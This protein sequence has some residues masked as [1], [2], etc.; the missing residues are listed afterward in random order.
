[1]FFARFRVLVWIAVL[2][3]A[4]VVYSCDEPGKERELILLH[5][6]DSHGSIV[7]VDSMGGM[8]ER[9]TFI[10][11]IREK[12]KHVLFVDAGDFNTGQAASNMADAHPDIAAY[13]YMG[14]DAVTVG[15]H[16]FDKPLEVLLKQ[17][18]WADF[19][20]VVSNIRQKGK[21]LGQEYLIKEIGGIKVGVFGITTVHTR[22]ISVCADKLDFEEEIHTAARMV[23]VL[24]GQGAD[25]V[26]GLVHLGFTETTPDYVTSRKLASQVD[27]IDILVDGHSHSYIEKPEWVNRT[28]IVTANQSGRYVGMGKLRVK[29]H[30]LTG[31]DWKPVPIK[32]YA[33]D[34]MLWRQL[35]PYIEVAHSDLQTVVGLAT[36]E[37]ALYERDEN[38][39]RYRESSLGNLVADALKWKATE[40]L[41]LKADF[42]L[43]NS[44]GIRAGLPAGGITREEVLSVLPFAN[45]LEVIGMSGADVRRLFTFIASVTPGNGAFAQVSGDVHVVYDR[46]ARQVK[47]LSIGGKPVVDTMIYY[48]A[49]CDYVAAGKDGYEAGLGNITYRENTSRLLSDVLADYI[50]MKGR[51][52]P[53]T[54]GRIEVK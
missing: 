32:G 18:E 7:P 17:M 35:E 14:Y 25:V 11:E 44:G 46:Q 9:A 31:F 42:G 8:A 21:I 15:N 28:W 10:R 51:I 27:G 24:R 45:V 19:P 49:T 53:Y 47:A 13:N 39:A 48:M 54:D 12:N 2:S 29:G 41:H 52:T 16:E 3:L 36:K 4:V 38:V 30:R 33:P 1:M 6:N 26:I 5:T 20:F 22:H 37:F 43:V 50:Q 23:K 34:T 40:G